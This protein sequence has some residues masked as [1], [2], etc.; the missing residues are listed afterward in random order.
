MRSTSWILQELGG[1]AR[2]KCRDGTK[3]IIFRD[4]FTGAYV[5][6]YLRQKEAG[7]WDIR[8]AVDRANKAAALTI[9]K[10][11][12]QK[13]IPWADQIDHFDAPLKDPD[14]STLT[15]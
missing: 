7:R 8:G 12:A 11:G 1:F 14:L 3:L 13:G 10:L 4:T 2:Y 6:E 9:K 15:I 5:S